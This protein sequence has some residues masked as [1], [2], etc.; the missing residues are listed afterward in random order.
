[1]YGIRKHILEEKRRFM[2]L[3]REVVRTFCVFIIDFQIG[4]LYLCKTRS[5]TKYRLPSKI[6]IR[7]ISSIDIYDKV[8]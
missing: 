7:F 6:F 1:M 8:V 4:V 2:I 5:E 3:K